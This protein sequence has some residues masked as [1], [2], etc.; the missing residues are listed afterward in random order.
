[1]KPTSPTSVMQNFRMVLVKDMKES[2]IFAKL[3]EHEPWKG[4]VE[5]EQQILL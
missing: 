5:E 1:M 3:K 2:F 4:S